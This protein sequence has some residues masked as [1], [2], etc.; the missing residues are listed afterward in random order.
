MCPDLDEQ[1]MYSVLQRMQIQSLRSRMH[2]LFKQVVEIRTDR[3]EKYPS[4]C[5]TL[6]E[7]AHYSVYFCVGLE[8]LAARCFEIGPSFRFIITDK[9]DYAQTKDTTGAKAPSIISPEQMNRYADK[10]HQ[11]RR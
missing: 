1:C 8:E 11:R 9:E 2:S 3:T 6:G 5:Y 7:L 4:I 10:Q